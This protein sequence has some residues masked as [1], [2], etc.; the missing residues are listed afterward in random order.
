MRLSDQ[1][2]NLGGA[3][4]NPAAGDSARPIASADTPALSWMQERVRTVVSGTIRGKLIYQEAVRIEGRISGELSSTELVVIAEGGSFQ[5]RLRTPK[6][7]VLGEFDGDVIGAKT[8][9]LGARARV[10][11][12]IQAESLVVQ[13]GAWLDGDVRV[14]RPDEPA[15]A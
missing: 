14:I 3:V 1:V 11:A 4:S 8:V 2:Q 15:D 6:L 10:K 7:L 12:N 5:G 9:M 13:E